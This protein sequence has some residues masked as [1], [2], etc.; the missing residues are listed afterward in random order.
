MNWKRSILAILTILS[1]YSVGFALSNSL[2]EPQVQAQL[3]LYQTNLILNASSWNPASD[4]V[5]SLSQNLIGES[6]LS[7]A[8]SSYE[9]ALELTE[10]NLNKL[11][12]EDNNTLVET[13][14]Q[15]LKQN[16]QRDTKLLDKLNLN[17]GI[18]NAQEDNLSL[19]INYWQNIRDKNLSETL[20]SIWNKDIKNDEKIEEIINN[21]LEGWFRIKTLEKFYSEINDNN[22]LENI[23]N[24]EQILAKKSVYRLLILSIIP[25]V[26]GL[27]GFGLII[28]LLI[29]L[30]VKKE[31]AILAVNSNVAW[32][33]PWDWEIIWQVFI[34]G[35]FF[36]SQV[37]LPL[38]FG[39]SGFNATA[40]DIKGKALYVLGTYFLMAGGGL[41]VLYFS[42]KSFSPFPEG[43]FK[44][45][46]KGWYWWG[47]G[48]YLV[49][50]PCVFFVSLFN[51]QLWQGKGGSNPLLLLALESQDKFALAIFFITACIAAPIFE[52]IMFRG[53]LLPSLT[54]YVP[55]WSAI[56]ISGVIFAIA[57][58]SLAETI[59]LATLGII[60][61]IVYT[62]SR[63]LLSSILVHSLWNSGT[64]FSLFLLGSEI[65]I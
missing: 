38:L 39:I 12:K 1:L 21:N 26:G 13:P 53:F 62:R 49:A 16:I 50:I 59:P 5:S 22:K 35:F 64:L 8:R 7:V 37:F 15:Q 29:Q 33:S 23:L 3:E 2:G 24:Q 27:I 30:L 11:K 65:N 28:F 6:P 19:A 44:L 31:N 54:R 52:E 9:K 25:M 18:I 20:I 42:L 14:R 41:S 57:H 56:V 43:W 32:E 47:F 60:L 48:G 51:Q 17:L 46:N 10:N 34:V 63:S 40:L 36:L 61:G 45:T 55:V 58:L 4:D